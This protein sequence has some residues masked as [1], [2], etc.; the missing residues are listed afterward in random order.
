V[1]ADSGSDNTVVLPAAN[2]GYDDING[3][4]LDNGDRLDLRSLLAG[5]DWIGGVA[6]IGNFIK[7]TASGN[8]AVIRI[9][10]SGTA[11][12]ATYAVA[13]LEDSGRCR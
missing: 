10:P 13:Q 4:V 7:L 3:Y 11:S 2:Q 1:L 5:T 8:S 6:G 9:D 12:G